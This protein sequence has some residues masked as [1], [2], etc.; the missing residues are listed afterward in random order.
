MAKPAI[1]GCI[2]HS[3]AGRAGS[4]GP[5]GSAGSKEERLCCVRSEH[6]GAE[7]IVRIMDRGKRGGEILASG[8]DGLNN[9]GVKDVFVF[10]VDG[11]K[12]FPDAIS[13]VFPKSDIQLCVVHMVRN[14][15]KKVPWKDRKEVA[16]DL[17]EIYRAGTL[18]GAEQ[19]LKEFGEKWDEKYPMI[20]SNWRGNWE[21]LIAIYKY[22]VEIRNV[23]YT[24]NAIESLNSVIR[25]GIKNRR[26]FPNRVGI[27]ADMDDHRSSVKEVDDA[28]P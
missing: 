3:L 1:G 5:S 9:R 23:I 16:K 27:E 8:F 11:L 22:P 25:K 21:N 24:T 28:N 13:G 7:G 6:G 26:I 18:D 4:K 19:A 20:S 2:S 14:S 12:G 10:C 15:L 17:R